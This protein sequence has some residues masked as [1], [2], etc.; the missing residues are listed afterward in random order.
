MNQR[1][2]ALFSAMM[3]G[4]ALLLLGIVV[5]SYVTSGG[6]LFTQITQKDQ[7]LN[8]ADAGLEWATAHFDPD[9]PAAIVG[10]ASYGRGV[11][12]IATPSVIVP[13]ER[14]LLQVTAYLPSKENPKHTRTIQSILKAIA[15]PI[16]NFAIATGGNLN[17]SG[18]ILVNSSPAPHEG[19]IHSNGDITTNGS[20][21][22]DG[23]TSASGLNSLDGGNAHAPRI[24]I[25]TLTTARIDALYQE[26]AANGT[27]LFSNMG[28]TLSG[29]YAPSSG[30]T[31]KQTGGATLSLSGNN[32]VPAGGIVFIDGDLEL[33]GGTTLSG[34]GTIIVNGQVKVTGNVSLG[35]NGSKLSI[36]SL[37]NDPE[38]I[39]IGGN[40]LA[41]SASTN[42]NNHGATPVPTDSGTTN[43]GLSETAAIFFAPVGGFNVHGNVSV[44]G[45]V[46]AGGLGNIN[47][48][49]IITRI[50]TENEGVHGFSQW[51]ATSW[52]EVGS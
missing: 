52:R 32:T 24:P 5:S 34:N 9:N 38:A 21:T 47:G 2:I 15:D 49:E 45:S 48:S 10:T 36:V 13:H 20:P 14:Y 39:D 35:G 25:P 26:A 29:Y 19:N 18:A 46:V 28:G 8:I 41:G 4:I 37:S 27:T 6:N 23:Q 16:F 51:K 42:G 12:E 33:S 11:Y 44:Y 22:V 43:S 17:M 30:W 40:V 50:T 3:L 31:P 1:G 7:A